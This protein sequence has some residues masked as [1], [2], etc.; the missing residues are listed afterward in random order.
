MA[1]EGK[2]TFDRSE[3]LEAY[4]EAVGAPEEVRAKMRIGKPKLE[5]TKTGDGEGT[6][7]LIGEQKTIVI[8][9]KRD[10]EYDSPAGLAYD[11]TRKVRTEKVSDSKFVTRGTGDQSQIVNRVVETRELVGDVLVVSLELDG[12]VCKRYFNRA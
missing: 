2:W 1:F 8:N 4:L 7:K 11:K 9:A 3:N 10:E 5:F 6:I 12:V